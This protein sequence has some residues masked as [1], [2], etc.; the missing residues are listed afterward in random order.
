MDCKHYNELIYT[1]SINRDENNN[2]TIWDCSEDKFL[3]PS[4][5][6]IREVQ[7]FAA[8]LIK[9]ALHLDHWVEDALEE[10]KEKT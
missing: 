3:I 5:E 9:K 10:L 6:Q 8:F 2:P 4:E 7:S 1:S